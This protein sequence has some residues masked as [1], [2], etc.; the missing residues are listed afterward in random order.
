MSSRGSRPPAAISHRA[1]SDPAAFESLR[2]YTV[3]V[4]GE[5][6]SPALLY[7]I[8]F[9][10]GF[11]DASGISRGFAG[12]GTAA[13][14]FAG[15]G[16]Q[17]LFLPTEGQMP[18]DFAGRLERSPEAALQTAPA[19]VPV[20]HLSAGY[21]AGWYSALLRV[22]LIVLE[23]SCTAQGAP[24]C[25]F[26][27]RPAQ[28]W[29]DEPRAQALLSFLNP[30]DLMAAGTPDED[31]EL[32][33]DEEGIL[34]RFDPMSA[35]AHVWGPIMVLPY[36]GVEDA[37]AALE[38]VQDDVGPDHVRVVLVD[39]TGVHLA[40][41]EACGV[42]EL[43]SRLEARGLEVLVVGIRIGCDGLLTR[44]KGHPP[45]PLLIESLSEGIA[46]AFQIASASDREQ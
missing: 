40:P 21:A 2:R 33:E 24:A 34:G 45:G 18:D 46:R 26:R 30:P 37:D 13:P 31:G 10:R 1:F 41:V 28:S 16:L 7:R 3:E 27:A 38:T 11:A 22:F 19:E 42:L 17:V 25:R 5:P 43:V 23:E 32:S 12:G 9:D 20:C 36:S 39:M 29:G 4:T 35:A 6:D 15:P 8:G 14:R 44:N